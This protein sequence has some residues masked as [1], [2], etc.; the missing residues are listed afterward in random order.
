ML[1][2]TIITPQKKVLE[3]QAKSVSCQTSEGEITI[4][5]RHNSL[6]TLLKQGLIKV[7]DDNDQESFFSAGSGYI[8]T[9]GKEVK[10]LISRAAGQ[11]DLDEKKLIEAAEQAKKILNEQKSASDRRQAWSML[12]R[13][14][15]DLKV[16]NKLK[17]RR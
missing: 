17:K 10:I 3:T 1:N 12:Q 16:V 9:D 2:L 4:L 15:L 5:P 14:S 6:L 7:K 11:S 13:T 8:E